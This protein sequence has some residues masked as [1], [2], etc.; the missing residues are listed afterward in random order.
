VEEKENENEKM[1]FDVLQIFYDY[2]IKIKSLINSKEINNLS[3]NNTNIK[4]YFG[5]LGQLISKDIE[6]LFEKM[7]A[8]TGIKKI[9]AKV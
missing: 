9:I 2:S 7:Y 3:L 6:D 5:K 8:Y 1:W 4:L